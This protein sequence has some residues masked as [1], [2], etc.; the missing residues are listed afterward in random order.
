MQGPDHPADSVAEADGG[1]SLDGGRQ[2]SASQPGSGGDSGDAMDTGNGGA[3]VAAIEAEQRGLIPRVLQ[4]VFR[5][6]AD[7]TAAANPTSPA[8]ASADSALDK[9]EPKP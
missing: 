4:R 1:S 9:V 2:V 7:Q 6:I 8:D 3:D 5:H